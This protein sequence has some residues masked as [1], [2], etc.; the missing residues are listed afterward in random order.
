RSAAKY[1]I[2]APDK[3]DHDSGR[4]V[5]VFRSPSGDNISSN[6]THSNSR[7]VGANPALNSVECDYVGYL[8][9]RGS[10]NTRKQISQRARLRSV[11]NIAKFSLDE[12]LDSAEYL[13]EN[14]LRT[15]EICI[16]MLLWMDSP[17]SRKHL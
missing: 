2:W 14:R 7:L 17:T 1:R 3:T 13:T 11:D 10:D 9:Y 12:I 15:F 16:G 6:L 5:A 4:I 8:Q